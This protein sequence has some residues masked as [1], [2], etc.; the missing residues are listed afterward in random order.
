MAN[1]IQG[2]GDADFLSGT[3]GDDH[4]L[5]GAGDDQL[6]GDAGQD[7]LSGDA[8]RD[9]LDGGEGAD[10]YLF[11]RGDGQ[12]TVLGG[13]G[14]AP[15]ITDTLR[16]GAGISLADVALSI[17]NGSDLLLK[18]QGSSDSVTLVN[19]F[20]QPFD[21][22][23]LIAFAD[24]SSL[25][26]LGVDNLVSAYGTYQYGTPQS[27]MVVGSRADD[28][29]NGMEGDDTLYGDAGRDIM[30]G[31]QGADTYLFGRGDGQDT[32]MAS[33]GEAP[34]VTDTLRLGAGI[35][36]VDVDLSVQYGSDLLLKL[37]GSSDS[38]TLAGYFSQPFDLR[39]LIAF[40]DGSSLNGLGV[41]N[42]VYANGIYQGGT[43]QS[44][45]VVGSRGDDQL[46]GMEGDDTLYGAAGRDFM[47][48]G[49]GADTYLF[50]RGDGQDTVMASYGEAPGVTDTLRLG[51]GIS[52]A[53]VD[54]STQNGSDLLLTLRGSS[55]S[56]T[57]AGYFS[58]P[59][60][61]RPLIAFADG[62]S[63]NGMSVDNLVNGYS[64]YQYGTPQSEMVVGSRGDDQLNGMEGDDTLYGDAGRDIMEGGQGTDTYLFGRG[65][66]QDTV[67]AYSGYGDAPGTS[68]TLRLGAGISLADVALSVQNGSDL[69][70]KLRGSSDSVTLANYFGVSFDRRPLITFADGSSLNGLG[71]DNLVWG[72]TIYQSGTT[73]SE[74]LVGSR[75]DDQLIGMEGDDTLYG[76][77]GR[78]FLDGGQGADT[79]LFGRGDGQDTVM[80]GYGDAP[81][82]TDTLRFAS[83]ISLADVSLSVQN[84]SDLLLKLRGSSDS[85]TL[86]NYFG[87]PFDQRP[88]ITF[89]DG[90]RLNGMGVDNLVYA[91]GIYQGG[92]PQ[93]E[94]V[95][96]SRG[97]DQLNGMEGDDTLYGDAGRDFLDGGQ[98]ADTYLFG[99]GDGQ[100]T[101]MAG[102]GDALGI[103]DTLR[104]GAGIT[105][106]DL[107]LSVQ[108]S[109]LLLQVQGGSDSV[110][111]VNY[112]SLP[113]EQRPLITF[114][115]GS[116][117]NGKGVDSLLNAYG[118][119]QYGTPQSE[120]V[121]GSRGDDQL[122]GM[123][124][125]DTLYGAAGR[126]IMEGGQ[127]ADTYLF[128]RGDGQDSV[129]AY[130]GYGD[131]PGTSDTLRLGSG[132]SL[133]D[134]ALSVQ[135]GSDLLL[136]LQGSSDSVTLVGYFSQ[137]FDLR[138]LIAFA[139]GSSLNGLGVDNLIYP[140]GIYQGGTPQSEMVMG[141]RGD[142]Q[143]MGMEGDD[144]LYGDAGRDFLDG[145]QGADTY[146]FG[147][148]D[149][150][151]TVMTGQ[152]DAPG[153]TDIL[154]LGAG[155]TLADVDLSVQNGSDLLF[156]LRGSSDSVTLA[157]YFGAPFDQR[158]LITF[159]DDS[160]LNGMGVDNLVYA[161]G[162]YQGGTPQSEMVV[163]S[164]GDDQLI[165]MEGDDTLYGD[166]GRDFMDGGQGADTYLFG[167]G[168]GQDT[169]M[170]SYGEVPGVTDTLRLGAGISLADVDL[171][172]QNG[173]LLITLF[174]SSDSVTLAGYVNTPFDRVPLIT[175]ADGLSLNAASAGNLAYGTGLYQFGTPQAEVLVGS[176]GDDELNGLDGDDKL[177]GAAGLDHLDGGLGADTMAGGAD[178]DTYIV[179]NTADVVMERLEADSAVSYDTILSSVSYTA[180]DNVEA[181]VLTGSADINAT[182]NNTGC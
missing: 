142:D 66:G 181:L 83:G 146:L 104:F 108:N 155:I 101:V 52:L 168:D 28:Q 117:L 50:G 20:N 82:I 160:S 173:D 49:Q 125:D 123:E 75:G 12:D 64:T 174:G 169:V 76:A 167:R 72:N 130:S 8:G 19:Y 29:L 154:R 33:Y 177:Y 149:G 153:I 87:A 2:T 85:V 162:I 30:E 137:P 58:Q 139:D 143:L 10:T 47:D 7:T 46:N 175:F 70:L 170:A 120:M 97:D 131:A 161:N 24:G 105:L 84:G 11:G 171:S 22:R 89:A 71:V 165:G 41:D 65:D 134:V 78:D 17:Q 57:L 121:V 113:F 180:P 141:S 93:S 103:T 6:I 152:G 36:L 48:G 102:W 116:S 61:L 96:G 179:D 73:Q 115:D 3:S 38:V 156:T 140:N 56:V 45:M 34:G 92:T 31:G 128:G 119:H 163:G 51:A 95:V 107:D 74:M 21:L 111:L 98:G 18:L 44:E 54:L 32:V 26:G 59:F 53:D 132:I 136:K 63:L 69:L 164:R 67:M 80:T 182:A 14:N 43:P 1:L 55:D 172:T 100:D 13:W 148:G 39:P 166:A 126:D 91:N 135:N 157:N 133:A 27:E 5:G 99:R 40:A 81:G 109:D 94:M 68:D 9:L 60:D 42:L 16:L 15:G 144:T 159:A 158:Q 150:Q 124:G 77:A 138:P 106:G 114:A 122:N 23:P 37:R 176:H 88:L 147:R 86:A 25:N 178:D 129:M 62:S 90:S 145:G 35:T 118:T 112:V 110:T 79:Y 4:M 151:D 127:G